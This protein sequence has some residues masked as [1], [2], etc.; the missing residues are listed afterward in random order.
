MKTSVI[1]IGDPVT[2]TANTTAALGTVITKENAT[3]HL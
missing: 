2:G 1:S 3:F